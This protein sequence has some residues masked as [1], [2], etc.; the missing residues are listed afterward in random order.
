MKQYTFSF[1]SLGLFIISVGIFSFVWYDIQKNTAHISEVHSALSAVSERD[2]SARSME[3]FLEHVRPL[4][5][6]LDAHVIGDDDVVAAIELIEQT[7]RRDEV[8]L[9]LSAVTI[10]EEKEWA[11]HEG[12][13][14]T[15]S[16]VGPFA[17]VV[18]F[19]AALES[20]PLASRVMRASL[21]ASTGGN[22]FGSFTVFFVK[23][24]Y[25]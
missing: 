16:A 7:A 23:E 24:K 9:S 6:S 17:R 20:L 2:E 3:M 18:S 13:E 8:R 25:E 21:E 5:E 15:L 11:H 12:I 4:K 10:V 19:A 22:W 1:I 14:V